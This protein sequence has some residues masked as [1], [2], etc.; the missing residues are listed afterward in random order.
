M[1]GT[2]FSQSDGSKWP[3]RDPI[4][5]VMTFIA[6]VRKQTL[7]SNFIDDF[8]P[9]FDHF[10]NQPPIPKA[11]IHSPCVS[12]MLKSFSEHKTFM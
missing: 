4:S 1:M 7:E 10:E 6:T 11:N 8:A 5:D 12:L 3:L 2:G 9:I